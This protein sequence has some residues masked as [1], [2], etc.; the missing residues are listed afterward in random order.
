VGVDL[1]EGEEEEM[2]HR[3]F[4]FLIIVNSSFFGIN[5]QAGLW[6]FAAISATAVVYLSVLLE[7][8]RVF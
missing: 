6:T 3:L 4:I 5:I 2:N 7:R 1:T 8:E